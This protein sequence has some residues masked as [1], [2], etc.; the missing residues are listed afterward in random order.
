MGLSARLFNAQP[1][2]L[3]VFLVILAAV[4]LTEA[5]VMFLLPSLLPSGGPEWAKALVDAC[6]LTAVLA[7]VFGWVIV[8]PLRRAA[9]LRLRLLAQF[10]AVQEEERRRVA[11]DLHDEI[12]QSLTAVL[13]GLRTL[14]T[15]PPTADGR[16]RLEEL[17]AAVTQA[18]QE[19][20]RLARG[21]RPVALDHLGLG[22]ALERY[23]E[24]FT[25][26]HGIP[27][28]VEATGLVSGP[29]PA[30]VETAAYRIVQEALTNTAKH[31]AANNA[32]VVVARRP[33]AL[34]VLIE[35]DGRG[36]D[37]G[38]IR[39]A[40]AEGVCLGLSGMRERAALLGGSVAVDA[41]PGGGTRVS[42]SLPLA[43]DDHGQDPRA[44]GG[45]PRHPPGRPEGAAE[46]AAGPRGRG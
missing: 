19:V 28:K 7:P 46:R 8:R 10:V 36:F 5:G 14:Q 12:G 20:R 30:A 9:K 6:L 32:R 35:D 42:V 38:A 13:L 43:E 26:V 33:S 22:P 18:L 4:F 24:D 27:V 40:S 44:A 31:A 34:H 21:L 1:Y 37:A 41:R 2:P 29:L 39:R 45:C 23:A 15:V 17:R 11:R 25:Q 3:R 16:Q